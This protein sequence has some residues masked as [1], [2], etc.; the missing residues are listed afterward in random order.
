MVAIV[1][2]VQQ[3]KRLGEAVQKIQGDELPGGRVES[4]ERDPAAG[5][6]RKAK[7]NLDPH[8]TVSFGR[9]VTVGEEVVEPAAQDLRER[10]GIDNTR[11]E[12]RGGSL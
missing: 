1:R 8:R 12:E 4:V 3:Q 11:F 9:Q 2:N 7:G 6:Y 10:G 5:K